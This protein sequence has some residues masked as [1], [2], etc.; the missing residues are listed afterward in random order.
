[1][2]VQEGNILYII[3]CNRCRL[4]FIGETGHAL[5][6]RFSKHKGY[7]I[8]KKLN[9]ATGA[10]FNLPGHSVDN[11]MVMAIQKIFT[12]GTPYRKEHEKE[13]I[14]NFRSYHHG[15]NRSAGG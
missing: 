9:Q 14:S 5:K 7:V 15:I 12:R 11:M 1:M 4:Q 3:E 10:H 2:L 8:N 13:E 6:E